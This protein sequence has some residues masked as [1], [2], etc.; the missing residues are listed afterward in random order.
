MKTIEQLIKKIPDEPGIYKF[1]NDQGKIIYIGKAKSLKKRVSSYF[2]KKKL[3]PKTDLMVS[4]ISDIKFTKVFSQFE[5][6]LL[7]AE[8]I[9]SAQPFFNIEAKDD[10]SPLYIKI[11]ADKFPLISTVRNEKP[12]HGVFLK[13]PFSGAGTAKDIL[14]MVR[15]IFP[16]CHHKNPKKPCLFVHLNLCPYPY[17]STQAK[18]EYI[19]NISKIKKLFKGESKQLIRDLRKEMN[20]FSKLQKFEQAQ[21]IKKKIEKLEFLATTYHAPKEFLE[22]PT[23]VDDLTLQ[24]LKK[25][26][27]VLELKNLPK[28][29]ECYDISNIQGKYPTGSM[30]VFKNGKPAKDQYRKFKIKFTEKPND[31]E[32]LREVLTRRLHNDWPKPDLVIIDGGR[33]QLNVALH[34]VAQEKL[35][36]EVI[37]IAK[38][39][40]EIYTPQKPLPISLPKENAA[41]QLVEEIRN[42]AH[43]FAI[44]YHRLLRS[45]IFIP[46]EKPWPSGRG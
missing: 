13:G 21:Q 41:R 25:L 30:V 29:I 12:K 17:S 45:K 22:T 6:L 23:L 37:S 28:R 11:S 38:R 26:Q 19:Q 1:L 14:K 27:E 8:E 16:Y 15:K 39:L 24:K 44:T 40:E 7:E 10:K 34:K 2:T 32:M 46:S 33:G 18:E 42:E 3:G 43:R 4:Q 31:Y 36:A 20:A 35:F 5:S 9:K